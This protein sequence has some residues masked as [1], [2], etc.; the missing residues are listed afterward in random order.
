MHYF[1]R[2]QED[3]EKVD[4]EN[5]EAKDLK[6]IMKQIYSFKINYKEKRRYWFYVESGYLSGNYHHKSYFLM[7]I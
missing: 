4:T 3:P 7:N 6:E 2:H 5:Q 1:L